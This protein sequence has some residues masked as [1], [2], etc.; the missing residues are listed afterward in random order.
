MLYLY[1]R[2]AYGRLTKPDVAEMRDLNKRELAM[3]VPVAAAVL[4]MGVYPESFLAPMRQDV[5]TLLARVE[6]ANPP[7]DAQLARGPVARPAG[8]GGTRQVKAG[9]H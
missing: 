7:G 2:V 4:W 9:A 6:R 3:L 1:W 5:G 8:D